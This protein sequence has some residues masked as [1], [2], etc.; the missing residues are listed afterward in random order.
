VAVD[1]SPEALADA[2]PGRPLRTY[3]AMLSTEA[4]AQAWARAGAPA[5][6]LVVADYQ[7]SPRGRGGLPWQVR[8]GEG[9]GFS[10]VLRPRLA[11][12]AEGW[13]YVAATDGLAALLSAETTW[14][15]EVWGRGQ[16][17]LA[18]VGVHANAAATGIDWVVVT[19]LI[20][21][22]SPPRTP[23]LGAA[24][25]AIEAHLA[26]SPD[27]VLDAYR[28]RC[29][30][31]GRRVRARLVPMGPAGIVLEGIAA[32]VRTNGGLVIAT[33]EGRRAVVPPQ[34]LGVL[35]VVEG[36]PTTGV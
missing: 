5:G 29:R 27:E 3:P 21:D 26:R 4:D 33:D 32:D 23:L 31:L 17:R 36:P 8:Q 9:L 7:A 11:P 13:P 14:P 10:V 35:E 18:A 22:A 28:G 16:R 25:E 30:T 1:L 20:A 15:D 12:E 34:D 19:V 6:A 24:L 2:L